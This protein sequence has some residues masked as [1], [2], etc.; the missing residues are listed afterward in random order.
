MCVCKVSA[1]L[2][3]IQRCF[4]KF[5]LFAKILILISEIL[6]DIRKIVNEKRL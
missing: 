3:T 4:T 1:R 2:L 6:I 5:C